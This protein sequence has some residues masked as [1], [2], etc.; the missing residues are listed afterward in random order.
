[1]PPESGRAARIRQ[2]R[3]SVQS[4]MHFQINLLRGLWAAALAGSALGVGAHDTWFQPLPPGR[5]G[6]IRLALGTG[7]KFPTQ[8]FAIDAK[9]LVRQGCYTANA[10]ANTPA[11]S[12][13][14]TPANEIAGR[15]AALR[16]LGNTATALLLQAPLSARACW[17]QLTPFDLTLAS[18]KVSV[19]LDEINAP[20]EVR[21]A[22][23]QLQAR[24]RPWQESYTKH[25]RIQLG[26]VS[27]QSGLPTGMGMDMLLRAAPGPVRV[28]DAVVVQVLREG[29]PLAGFNVEL[30]SERSQS[31][32]GSL[33]QQTDA[34]G[35]VTLKP[36][37]PGRWVLRGTDLAL[38]ATRPDEWESRFITLA[39]EV[40]PALPAAAGSAPGRMP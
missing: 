34:E 35:R 30:R 32:E 27:A 20:A 23:D 25:A 1:M 24:G 15:A 21:T 6:E 8:E 39:F 4:R 38:S 10:T 28:S 33:W 13:T 7:D 40:A 37:L 5:T 36:T 19:Y 17:A 31:S 14:N 29:V 18:D 3:G 16:A 12:T 26:A 9:Y 2:R 22:W 11:N